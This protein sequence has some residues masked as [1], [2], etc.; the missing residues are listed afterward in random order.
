MTWN[1]VLDTHKARYPQMEPKDFGKLLYQSCF[2]PEHMISNLEQAEEGILQEWRALEGECAPNGLEPIGGG[3]YR[4]PLNLLRDEKDAALLARM[5]AATARTY[6]Q[7]PQAFAAGLERLKELELPGMKQWL[8]EYQTIGCPSVSHSE[9]FRRVYH[10]HYRLV[11]LEYA[12]FFPVFRKIAALLERQEPVILAIDG[13]CGSGKSTLGQVLK[14][15]FD[16]PVV[17][18]DDYYLP[19]EQRA[20][21]WMEI[22]AGNMDLERLRAEVLEPARRREVVHYCPYC[23]QTG[24]VGEER[25]FN[26]APFLVVEGSYSQHPLLRAYYDCTIFLTCNKEEQLKRLE[27][28]EGSYFPRFR[29]IWMPLEENYFRAYSVQEQA[30]LTVDNSRAAAENFIDFLG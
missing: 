6:V 5:F 21:R 14:E 22:P 13:R 7:R 26:P 25:L 8:L 18:M 2:G 19:A 30:E 15:I 23:C 11:K 3:L 28:R 20:E 1:E 4:F 17:H 9:H 10:P 29:E 16:C 27:K 24:A 12:R